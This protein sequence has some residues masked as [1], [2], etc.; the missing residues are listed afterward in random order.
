M[1][2]RAASFRAD[3]MRD[4]YSPPSPVPSIDRF[5]SMS[6]WGGS[7]ASHCTSS[8]SSRLSHA[9]MSGSKPQAAGTDPHSHQAAVSPRHINEGLLSDASKTSQLGSHKAQHSL[10]SA[11]AMRA[12]HD[13]SSSWTARSLPPKDKAV[14]KQLSAVGSKPV[15]IQSLDQPQTQA[16]SL[17]INSL[18]QASNVVKPAAPAGDIVESSNAQAV[19]EPGAL[20][21]SAFTPQQH[22]FEPR[23]YCIHLMVFLWYCLVLML[24][25]CGSLN[26]SCCAQ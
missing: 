12:M 15:L 22:T 8:H 17:E 4:A 9:I 13:S 3:S 21:A 14:S 7:S 2:A 1:T 26:R 20:L 6:S 18:D 19:N 23:V 24:L 25:A 5:S 11:S 16:H 10:V